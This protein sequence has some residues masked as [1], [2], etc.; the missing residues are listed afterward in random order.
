ML[1][2]FTPPCT[3][4]QVDGVAMPGSMTK[5]DLRSFFLAHLVHSFP[6]GKLRQVMTQGG[7]Y[8]GLTS[9]RNTTPHIRPFVCVY[10]RLQRY[11]PVCQ[12]N[13]D[14]IYRR[15]T[16]KPVPDAKRCFAPCLQA[17]TCVCR[18]PLMQTVA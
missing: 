3:P 1:T 10:A 7:I 12:Y 13:Y 14:Y 2:G 17:Y 4:W 18:P 11:P 16:G 6:L 9:G 15:T 5:H 8:M